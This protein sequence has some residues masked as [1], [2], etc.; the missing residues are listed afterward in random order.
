MDLVCPPVTSRTLIASFIACFYLLYQSFHTIPS[1]NTHVFTSHKL[2]QRYF[3]EL[4]YEESRTKLCIITKNYVV[5]ELKPTQNGP[6]GICGEG[7]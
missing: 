3:I 7:A 1:F 2:N 6:L 5:S 4:S